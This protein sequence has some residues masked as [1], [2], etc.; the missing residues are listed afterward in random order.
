MPTQREHR[1]LKVGEKFYPQSRAYKWGGLIVTPWQT[2][3]DILFEAPAYSDSAEKAL[4]SMRDY[5]QRDEFVPVVEALE[6]R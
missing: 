1:V 5:V 4:E 2:Y 6:V 3:D